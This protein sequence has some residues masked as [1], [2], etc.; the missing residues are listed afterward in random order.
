MPETISKLPCQLTFTNYNWNSKMAPDIKKS[1]SC[2]ICM[3]LNGKLPSFLNHFYHG[4]FA[5][6]FKLDFLRVGPYEKIPLISQ[7]DM[8]KHLRTKNTFLLAME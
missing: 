8:E 2:M 7:K 4:H 3:E 1:S 5:P 6:G